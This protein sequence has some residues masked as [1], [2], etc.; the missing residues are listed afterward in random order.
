[1]GL[2]AYFKDLYQAAIN[3]GPDP[4][5][6]DWLLIGSFWPTAVLVLMY[7]IIIYGGQKV[8]KNREPFQ[9]K[10]LIMLYNFCLVLLNCYIFYE[11]LISSVLNS[12]FS[13][14]CQPVDRSDDALS[15][16]LAKVCWWFYVSKI[17][18][19]MDTVFFMLR[20]K[21]SQ[22][23]FLHVYH[24]STM[25]LLWWIGVKMVPGGEAYFSASINSFIHI[26]M[27]TYYLLSA[28]G[29]A[30][31]K[32][33]WWKKY[34][35]MLQLAQF[36]AIMV[37]TPYAMY[38]SCGFPHIYGWSLIMYDLSHLILFS[39]FYYQTYTK[40]ARTKKAAAVKDESQSDGA[41]P[42]VQNGALHDMTTNADMRKRSKKRTE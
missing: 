32:Y 7:G 5:S 41:R 19:F 36:L 20:K 33:L 12:K 14:S 28:M 9:L 21:D 15:L 35:T 13:L 11:F 40:K 10:N 6:Q 34:M 23:S 2:I 18:E 30:M 3:A 4:R 24:H 38:M 31:Q 37:K 8:M 17:I 27:Y 42:H 29:P 16:R 25:P 26:V 39:N 1:M 22:I